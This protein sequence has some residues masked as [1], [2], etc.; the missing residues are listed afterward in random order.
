MKR[1][2]DYMDSLEVS[3]TLHA[4]L[5][6]LEPPQKRPAAWKRCVAAAAAL[7]LAAGVGAWGLSRGGWNGLMD[8]FRPTGDRGTLVNH[9]DPAIGTAEA[10]REEI[11][12]PDIAYEDRTGAPEKANG[13]GY[14]VVHGDKD[15]PNTVVSYYVLPYLNWADASAQPQTSLDYALAPPSAICR[16]AAPDDVQAFAG[17][18]QAM[19]DHLLWDGLDWSGWFWFLED[20][21]PCAAGRSASGE[22]LELYLEVMKGGKVPSCIVFPEDSY[23]R[24]TWGGIE[25][26]A[27]K[28]GGYMTTDG[29]VEL[30]EKREVSFLFDGVGY[31]LTLYADDAGRADELCARF[32]RYAVDGGFHLDVLSADGTANYSGTDYS[33]GAPNYEDGMTG[34]FVPDFVPDYDPTYQDGVPEEDSGLDAVYCDCPECIA[35]TV[36]THPY[37][38][39]VT[40]DPNMTS[41]AKAPIPPN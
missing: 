36:H 4:K 11:G 18:E 32:V 8:N 19:A 37:N 7:V 26:T 39:G 3:D 29:G 9:F 15:D 25:I 12:E 27:L 35:G 30:R 10:G 2:K 14:E 1:Y 24:S 13:G 34:E 23:E 41:E 6:N 20:G 31:K 17:G 21:T 28:N 38:P 22:N 33:V 5:E 16:H 40:Y